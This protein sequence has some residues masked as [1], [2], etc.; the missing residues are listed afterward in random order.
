MGCFPDK[1]SD[2]FKPTK[3]NEK[4]IKKI[5]KNLKEMHEEFYFYNINQNIIS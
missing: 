5:F 3:E 2:K 1:K 4:K